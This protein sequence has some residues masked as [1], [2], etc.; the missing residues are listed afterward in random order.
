MNNYGMDWTD[1]MLL[2]WG[3][4]AFGILIAIAHFTGI[5]AI[6]AWWIGTEYVEF[7]EGKSYERYDYDR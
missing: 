1:Q 5:L 7:I 2:A 6:V 4:V 3:L